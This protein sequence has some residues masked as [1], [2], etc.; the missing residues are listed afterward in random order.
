M[1]MLLY[2]YKYF[3]IF[4]Q[5]GN[6]TIYKHLPLPYKVIYRLFIVGTF[7]C[8]KMGTMNASVFPEPVGAQANTSRPYTCSMN[9]SN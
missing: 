3:E 1:L 6:V 9:T 7:K 4:T 5:N 8:A 2:I